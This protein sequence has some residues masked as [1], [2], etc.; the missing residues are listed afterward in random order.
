VT[1]S[2][3]AQLIDEILEELLGAKA[4]WGQRILESGTIFSVTLSHLRKYEGFDIRL[5]IGPPGSFDRE[6]DDE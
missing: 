2:I 6:D 5:S 4:D 3:G 1:K